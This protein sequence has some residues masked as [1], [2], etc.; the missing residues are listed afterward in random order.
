M[1]LQQEH[2][3]VCRQTLAQISPSLQRQVETLS[4][5]IKTLCSHSS[6]L[7]SLYST[8]ISQKK[9]GCFITLAPWE[10]TV[11]CTNPIA[12]GQERLGGRDLLTELR[13]AWVTLTCA[14]EQCSEG[15][16]GDWAVGL[17]WH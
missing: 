4:T 15:A 9:G 5:L 16:P 17:C 6:L 1:F 11:T 7:P 8:K 3:L 14:G 10:S 12:Y 2:P 13:E